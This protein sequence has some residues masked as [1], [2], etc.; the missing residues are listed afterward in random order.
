MARVCYVRAVDFSNAVR[1]NRLPDLVGTVSCFGQHMVV[2]FSKVIKENRLPDSGGTGAGLWWYGLL[3]N[4][5]LPSI[6]GKALQKIEY[7]I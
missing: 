1:R 4:D 3:L 6:L 2:D 7:R 5:I